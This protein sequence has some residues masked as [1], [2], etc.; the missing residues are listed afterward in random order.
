MSASLLSVVRAERAR[1]ARMAEQKEEA[2]QDLLAFVRMFWPVLEPEKPLIEGWLLDLLCDV[3]MAITDGG[4]AR[5]CINVPPGSTKSTLLNVMWPAWEW[6][7]CARPNLR[8]LSISYS[9]A[10]PIRDNLRFVQLVKH[11][12]Y[13][14][15]WGDV[16]KISREGAEWVANDATG[17][18]MVSST[19]GGVTGF[20]GDR[21]LLDDI[22]NPMDVESETVRAATNRFVLE[23]MPS[24]INDIR[25]S[26][27]INLQ[28]RTH[29]NDATGTLIEKSEG[30]TFVCVPMQ[31]DPLRICSFPLEFGEDGEPTRVWT[32]PRALGPDGKLLAGLG[33]NG[34][35]EPIVKM[36]SPMARAEGTICWPE[37]FPDDPPGSYRRTLNI[38]DYAWDSQFNQFPGVRGGGIIRS[39]WWKLWQGEAY[40][41]LG[42]VIVSVDTATEEGAHNDYNA[43]TAWGAFAG[44]EG[45]P[46]FLLL[47]AWRARI[48]LAQ[49]QT[50]VALTCRAWGADYLLIE[51]RSRGRDLADEIVR[52]NADARWEVV[53]IDPDK[54]KEARLRAVSHLF[55]GDMHKSPMWVG[56]C[57]HT[58]V[59]SAQDVVRVN[60]KPA[61]EVECP[62]CRHFGPVRADPSGMEVWEGNGLIFAPDKDWAAEVISEVGAF[63]Y[64]AHDDYCDTVSQALSFARK[65]GVVLRKVEYQAEEAER[66][67]YRKPMGTPYAI[68]KRG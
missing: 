33:V 14:R 23:V 10:V 27:I 18:K 43:C 52:L 45:Q 17:W 36:G 60:R 51:K 48:P 64:G 55:S 62:T 65:N 16:V 54:S 2:E 6:G 42:T 39:D 22:N 21:V 37:R 56:A 68:S 59:L 29:Q 30:Y 49:L 53:L 4:M 12:V 44:E 9:T 28:Q 38:T 61:T 8:Y 35:G 66:R 25:Q 47:H 50:R 32:D 3:L 40:P 57:R 31:F 34:R 13:Q 58:F 7:P 26:A 46:Q 1:R 11:P 15:C 5:V 41:D 63:P 67:R 20:R 24:R 19:G